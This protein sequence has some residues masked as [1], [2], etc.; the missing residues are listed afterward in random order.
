MSINER[1]VA[2]PGRGVA[3]RPN[4]VLINCDDLG[5]GDLGCYGSELNDTPTLDRMAAE[6]LRFTDFYMA[7]PV[8]SPSRGAA[9]DGLLPAAASGSA[10]SKGRGVLFPGQAGRFEPGRDHAWPRCSRD[11]GYA[12]LH[13]RQV[14]LRRPAGVPAHP[15][16][17][18][19]LLRASRTATTWAARP[20]RATDAR[21]A[22]RYP[23]LPLLRRRG[24]D[25][26]TTRPGVAHRAL[27]RAR[28]AVH[29]RRIRTGPF[30]LYLAHMY[31]HLPI[32]VRGAV[33]AESRNGRYGAAV[34]SIDWAT[35]MIAGRAPA[36]GPGRAHARGLHQRQRRARPSD[37]G[38]TCPLR[39]HKG[40]TWDGG[41]RV[42]GHH[43]LARTHRPGTAPAMPWPPR[44]TF[45]PRS[46]HWPVRARR[47]TT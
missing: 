35:E 37:G 19:P 11:A 33:P 45:C 7:S 9:A 25:R 18:R 15:P 29:A 36:A 14:A 23:P 13:R 39:G 28:R 24:G 46:P 1:A 26:G 42:P 38:R 31:V 17:L 34:A 21:R 41:M 16:R 20:A 8:C 27:R 32:Y 43:A 3:D 4:I 22:G 44:W 12:T 6:G 30:F 40:S 2:D 10:R 5:Y 47:A